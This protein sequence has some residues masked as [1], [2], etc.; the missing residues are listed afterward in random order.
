MLFRSKLFN[1]VVG[2]GSIAKLFIDEFKNN[3]DIV[4]FA[5]G[6]SDSNEKRDNQFIREKEL[7]VKTIS[8]F[9]NSKLVYFSSIFSN[10]VDNDYYRHKKNTEDFIKD[11]VSNYLIIRLPQVIS[12]T[13]NQNNLVNFFINSIKQH[14]KVKIQK[15][16]KRALVDVEDVKIL[17]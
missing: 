3:S 9:P 12:N 5:S 1:M 11:N 13:G 14:K 6:V 2:N 10:Y 7:L 4:I 15:H 17:T 8:E 16:T